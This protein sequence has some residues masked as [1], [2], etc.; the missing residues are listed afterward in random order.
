[1][2][3]YRWI[4]GFNT[5]QQFFLFNFLENVEIEVRINADFNVDPMKTSVGIVVRDVYREFVVAIVCRHINW[6]STSYF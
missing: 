2:L 4:N 3:G 5:F 6:P 1:M